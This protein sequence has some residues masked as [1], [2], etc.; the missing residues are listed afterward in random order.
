MYFDGNNPQEE[1]LSEGSDT[2]EFGTSVEVVHDDKHKQRSFNRD[3]SGSPFGVG[4]LY[5]MSQFWFTI[6]IVLMVIIAYIDPELGSEDGPLQTDIAS[7]IIIAVVLF[8][9]GFRLNMKELWQARKYWRAHVFVQVYNLVF[10]PLSVFGIVSLLSLLDYDSKLRTGLMTMACFPT[11]TTA[12]ILLT[13]AATGNELIAVFNAGVGNLLGI[14]ITPLLLFLFTD[15]TNLEKFFEFALLDILLL[16]IVPFATGQLLRILTLFYL[17]RGDSSSYK[18]RQ[19][20]RSI[21]FGITKQSI[22][23]GIV[24]Q[25][26]LLSLVYFAF[27]DTFNTGSDTEVRSVII[28]AVITTSLHMTYFTIAFLIS[29]F[30]FLNFSRKDRIA[31]TYA[32]SQK[33]LAVGITLIDILYSEDEEVVGLVALPLLIYDPFQSFFGGVASFPLRRWA[34]Q[35]RSY[36]LLEQEYQP[37]PLHDAAPTL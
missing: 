20:M 4:K 33:T 5:W 1:L 6:A 13:V 28:V 2:K 26:L 15:I 29:G 12:C 31:I 3:L 35:E 9:T 27:C 17:S 14:V 7:K 23:W 21:I 25:I 24:S 11:S 36:E 10:I 22:P 30:R 37:V 34:S 19:R 32:A 18:S 8:L 16:L